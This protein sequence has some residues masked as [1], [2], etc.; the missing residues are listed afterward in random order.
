MRLGVYQGDLIGQIVGEIEKAIPGA[1]VR[2]EG[3]GGHFTIDVLSEAFR[4]KSRL[5]S[6][7]LVLSAIAPLMA[8][9]TAPVHAVDRLTTRVPAG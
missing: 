6:Q 2:V 5:E 4:D 7:R 1:E 3:Q 9:E 8:G